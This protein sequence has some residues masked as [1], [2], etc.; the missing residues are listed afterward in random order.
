MTTEKVLE[1]RAAGGR[2]F[3][4][5]IIVV[6]G[7]GGQIGSATAR[8]VAQEGAAGVVV[9]DAGEKSANAVRDELRDFGTNAISYIGD[10]TTWE[11]AEGLMNR[12]KEEY[13]RIDGL[14]NI[15]GGNTRQKSFWLWDPK[16]IEWDFAINFWTTMWCCRAVLPIMLEQGSGSIVNIATHGVVGKLR[17]PYAAGKGGNIAL[18]TSISREVAEFGVRVNVVAP[19]GTFG[20]DRGIPRERLFQAPAE[21]L[22]EEEVAL[23]ARYRA[24]RI[25]EVPMGR[26]GLPEEQA[27]AIAF[28]LSDDASYITGQVLPV[29]GG[30]AYPF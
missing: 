15:A 12:A 4:G 1:P 23:Q 22:P 9:T 25:G 7:G 27:S 6:T 11:T 8:R 19:S 5:K 16:E 18:A 3:E 20:P 17:V 13:G 30:Q 14:A 29:G 26:A 10:L 21:E 24:G 2:R 28:L